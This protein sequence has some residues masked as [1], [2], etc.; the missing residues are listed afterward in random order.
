MKIN[1]AIEKKFRNVD[2]EYQVVA[3]LM[4]KSATLSLSVEPD[5]FTIRPLADVVSLLR[6]LKVVL[7]KEAVMHGLRQK[8]VI[9]KDNR[10]VYQTA[11]DGV[12][13][14]KIAGL[15]DKSLRILSKQLYELSESRKCLLG[16]REVITNIKD[17]N[18]DK[19][20]KELRE[21]SRSI[22]FSDEEKDVD[23]LEDF[24]KRKKLIRSREQMDTV[25]IPTG[26]RQ[27]D[28]I[29]G[30]LMPGEF[31]IIAGKPGVGKTAALI[32][33]ALHAWLFGYS[34]LFC[35]GEMSKDLVQFRMDAN[36]AGIPVQHF[37]TG[38]LAK[39]EWKTWRTKMKELKI[40]QQAFLEVS[41]FARHFTANDIESEITRVQEK[42]DREVQLLCIDYINIMDPNE[43]IRDSS[44]S[45][46]GQANVV[47]DVKGL[48]ADV[49]GGICAWS[50]GQIVD[51][52]FEADFLELDHL[53]YARKISETAPVVVG[54]VETQDDLLEGRVQWQVLKM[55]N[56]PRM[57]KSL[58][59][60]P[61]FELMRLHERVVEREQ[62]DLKDLEG[63]TISRKP[64]R[65]RRY[66]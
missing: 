26:I 28:S 33:F 66:S 39:E 38:E 13:K 46:T 35:S 56:A 36:L 58:Y 16:I 47:W 42:W 60:H 52:A 32:A 12:G 34:V 19:A 2:L 10:V 57:K 20:K 65:R 50:A 43:N 45:W 27:F 7:S 53:K 11:I 3:F 22:S 9:T 62:K 51:K 4:R 31:G 54:L 48:V 24:E 44:S 15:S 1:E 29:V 37:R 5:W 55:R 59:L 41:T 40:R 30:G 17:F 23:Y 61:N 49:N 8:S 21:L 18:L 14:T 6:D 63:D 64:K 25:G